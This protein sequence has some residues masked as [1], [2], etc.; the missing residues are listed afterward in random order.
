[1]NPIDQLTNEQKKV[2]SNY[3][4]EFA[5]ACGPFLEHD[6]LKKLGKE[7]L[8]K[9]VPIVP[10]VLLLD[11]LLQVSNVNFHKAMKAMKAA[12]QTDAPE[13]FKMDFRDAFG[14]YLSDDCP[15]RFG[16]MFKLIDKEGLN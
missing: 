7:T 11:A 15:F 5:K 16:D 8:L 1:M 9:G 13:G 3:M 4:H 10:Q 14:R 2:I 6:K 12:K